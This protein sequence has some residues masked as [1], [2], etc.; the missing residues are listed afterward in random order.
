[1]SMPIQRRP[2]LWAAW[3]AVPQ[4]QKGLRMTSSGFEDAV[5]I[6]SRSASGFCVG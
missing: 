3:T 5:M 6:R 4:P 1:M 2:S